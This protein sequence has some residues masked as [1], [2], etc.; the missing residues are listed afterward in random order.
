MPVSDQKDGEL[1]KVLVDVGLGVFV[2]FSFLEALR[3]C[4]EKT[5][6]LQE[7]VK[8]LMDR[9]E[10]VKKHV[11][12]ACQSLELLMMLLKSESSSHA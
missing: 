9:R 4:H 7:R 12:E 8:H 6:Y 10:M 1:E 11:D 2:E 3:F 5:Y